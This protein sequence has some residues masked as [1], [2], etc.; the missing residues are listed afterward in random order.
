MTNE[1]EAWLKERR[2]GIGASE[3][4]A[5][6]GLSPWHTPYTVWA[7]KT[8]APIQD[9]SSVDH[10]ERLEWGNRLEPAILAEA[11][12]RRGLPEVPYR[13]YRIVADRECSVMFAT[14]DM[15]TDGV[16]I[17]AKN[18]DKPWPH[19]WVPEHIQV[20]VQHEMG[21]TGAGRAIVAQ[22]V[23][24][25]K[26][27]LWDVARDDVAIHA[28][29]EAC[30]RFWYKHVTPEWPPPITS[31]L[32]LRAVKTMFSK[33]NGGTIELGPDGHGIAMHHEDLRNK[34]NL[35]HKDL[36]HTAALLRGLMG[37]ASM[38][39][40]PDGAGVVRLSDVSGGERPA[41]TVAPHRKLFVKLN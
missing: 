34:K 28:I 10:V 18:S 9:D 27:E 11:C 15:V 8:G 31:P 4:A 26:L 35:I 36:N 40:L 12:V 22:L 32:D 16:V 5:L 25:C 19:S 37:G 30:E 39:L 38:G 33:G 1:R 17:Q 20:Q 2:K 24:G 41:H 29:R 21:V 7:D 13:P 23:S 6:F 14:P 3:S